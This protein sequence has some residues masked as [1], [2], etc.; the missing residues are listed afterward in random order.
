[1]E[2]Y[3]VA[4]FSTNSLKKQSYQV[5]R[6]ILCGSRNMLSI[7]LQK[8]PILNMR[9]EYFLDYLIFLPSMKTNFSFILVKLQPKTYECFSFQ[10]IVIFFQ[11][12]LWF[13]NSFQ[14]FNVHSNR[15]KSLS[16]YVHLLIIFNIVNVNWY[17]F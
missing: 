14:I 6:S 10:Q 7:S 8:I 13:L 16:T 1:M 12:M 9:E 11:D 4:I 5:R 2:S 17:Y 3:T 15:N